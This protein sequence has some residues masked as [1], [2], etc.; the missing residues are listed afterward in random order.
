[1]W[2]VAADFTPIQLGRSG[3]AVAPAVR[4][5]PPYNGFG[6]VE[7][8][9]SSCKGLLPKPPE[10]DFIKFMQNDSY[11]MDRKV[12]RYLAQLDTSEPGNDDRRF[13]ISYFLS[14]DTMEV[15]EK[16]ASGTYANVFLWE[17]WKWG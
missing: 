12:L 4:E 1:M 6:S 15:F 3:D 5:L 14:D 2:Y 8:S 16:P 9:L 13:I 17:I 10:K 7:D 11:G